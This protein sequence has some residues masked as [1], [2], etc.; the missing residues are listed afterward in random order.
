VLRI[1][2]GVAT[3]DVL[4]VDRGALVLSLL[5]PRPASTEFW[6]QFAHN[7]CAPA[8]DHPASAIRVASR[9]LAGSA[10]PDQHVER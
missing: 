8:Y 3:P 7:A 1:L 9:Q 5:Q 2:G 6:E 4:V 10:H